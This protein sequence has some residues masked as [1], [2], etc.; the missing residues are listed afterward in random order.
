MLLLLVI[1]GCY[2]IGWLGSR[3][4]IKVSW[5]Q[6]GEWLLECADGRKLGAAL[7]GGSQVNAGFVCL[8]LYADDLSTKSRHRVL[9]MRG[10][11]SRERWR[12]LRVRLRLEAAH[13]LRS[14][15][16]GSK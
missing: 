12:R 11:V 14:D 4:P 7:L 16:I 6:S 8:Q 15:L 9:L 13:S 10:E 5:L 2:R 1:A 3:R